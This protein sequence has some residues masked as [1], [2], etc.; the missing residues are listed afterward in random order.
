PGQHG[1]NRYW[2]WAGDTRSLFLP[3]SRRIM[4]QALRRA[5]LVYAIRDNRANRTIG[6]RC[7]HGPGAQAALWTILK[8]TRPGAQGTSA[9]RVTPVMG[10]RP[11][12]PWRM[13]LASP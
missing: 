13:T 10:R 5:L 2:L 7:A 9:L 3:A 6:A 4:A 8:P 1:N 11:S 12:S